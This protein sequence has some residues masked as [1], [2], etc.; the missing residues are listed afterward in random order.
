MVEPTDF[1][2]AVEGAI[3]VPQTGSLFRASWEGTP[4]ARLRGPD[5]EDGGLKRS[6]NPLAIIPITD[7]S[8]LMTSTLTIRYKIARNTYFG[9]V[10]FFFGAGAG[11]GVAFLKVVSTVAP[12]VDSMSLACWAFGPSGLSCRYFCNASAV[13]AGGVILPSAETVA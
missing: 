5:A 3:K 4:C 2:T 11:A 10:Y 12:K 8:A 9:F 7:R 6:A 13:P 1:F